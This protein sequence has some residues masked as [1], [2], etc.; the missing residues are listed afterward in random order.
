MEADHE[1]EDDLQCGGTRP[2]LDVEPVEPDVEPDVR[3]ESEIEP[4]LGPRGM[5]LVWSAWCGKCVKEKGSSPLWAQRIVVA[6]LSRAEW[7]QVM[8]YLFSDDYKLQ[9]YALNRITVWRS[10]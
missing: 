5:D 1:M 7:D 3:S 10:R 6:W 9:R 8:V 4:G 2:E